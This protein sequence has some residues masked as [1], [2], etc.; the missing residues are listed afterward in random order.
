MFVNTSFV[1]QSPIKE[2]DISV[3]VFNQSFLT[4]FFA[5]TS[6]NNNTRSTTNTI[7]SLIVTSNNL[8]ILSI[9]LN[10][11]IKLNNTIYLIWKEQFKHVLDVYGLHSLV[12]ST[13]QLPSKIIKKTIL[14]KVANGEMQ[15]YEILKENI[16][17]H[18]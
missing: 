14:I 5:N 1:I 10:F 17:Y 8:P 12:D 13:I 18:V 15:D 6:T 2:G 9:N 3:T 16:A 4:I 11:S 7:S